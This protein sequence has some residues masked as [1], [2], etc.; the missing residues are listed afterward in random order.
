M[1]PSAQNA[2][3]PAPIGDSLPLL[4]PRCSPRGPCT[5][6]PLRGSRVAHWWHVRGSLAKKAA[7]SSGALT[8]AEALSFS[9]RTP[10]WVDARGLW[11]DI[12]YRRQERLR[13][14][15]GKDSSSARGR[16]L[17]IPIF[18]EVLQCGIRNGPHL[19]PMKRPL[20]VPSSTS[21]RE[22]HCLAAQESSC[23][24]T[25]LVGH[26]GN[27]RS[28]SCLVTVPLTNP[29]RTHAPCSSHAEP[30][31]PSCSVSSGSLAFLLPWAARKGCELW[32]GVCD[33]LGTR[34]MHG[35]VA[36]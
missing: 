25:C 31:R 35:T 18:P 17:E 15:G 4:P 29:L 32:N 19:T 12:Y 26:R 28:H 22:F 27:P 5:A 33:L 24:K 7:H 23:N 36:V 6:A 16:L 34:S 13:T 30:Q 1:G 14:G 20:L 21:Q 2:P 8:G 11:N 10:A 9:A 3:P